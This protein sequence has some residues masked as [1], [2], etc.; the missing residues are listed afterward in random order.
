MEIQR[1]IFA[2]FCG[3]IAYIIPNNKSNIYPPLLGLIFAILFTKIVFG[4]Y[5]KGYQWTSSDILF[6]FI[7]GSEGALGTLL[8]EKIINLNSKFI[9]RDI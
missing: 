2:L 7:V 5:D 4:D 1:H 6:F 3:T 9:R 8:T